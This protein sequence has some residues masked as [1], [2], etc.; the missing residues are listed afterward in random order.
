MNFKGNLAY[1]IIGT[2]VFLAIYL[3]IA[4]IPIGPDLYFDPV[5]AVKLDSIPETDLSADSPASIPAGD[6]I[7]PFILGS[8]F[9]YFSPS[10]A[11]PMN[12]RTGD[13]ATISTVGWSVY[14]DSPTAS[15][16]RFRDGS[17]HLKIDAE[18][19]PYL[20]G[21]NAYLFLPGG[22]A[23]SLYGRSGARI[24]TREHSAPITAFA[25]SPG[26]TAIG[27]ADGCLALMDGDGEVF[28]FYPGGSDLQVVLGSA[29]SRDGSLVACVSGIERQRF[30]LISVRGNTHKILQHV[31]LDGDLRRR[32]HVAFERSGRFAFFET[33]QGLGVIDSVKLDSWII[34]VPGSIVS[35]GECLED[36]LFVVLSRD[37]GEFVLSAIERPNH[38]VASERFPGTVAFMTQR[39]ASVY[40]GVD[41]TISR[42]DVRGL[43]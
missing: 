26:G 38:V 18:G 32:V 43:K 12:V 34:P 37:G 6:D 14:R 41:G 36:T 39:G 7:E 25:S 23:V 21:D 31:Y 2:I 17:G 11:I 4:S 29:V 3:V 27:Y 22:D 20:A 13:R 33:A 30:L 9:G 19:F 35:T 5:W 40:L 15:D 16:I 10:G 8:R 24:W 1:I 42:I 28:S